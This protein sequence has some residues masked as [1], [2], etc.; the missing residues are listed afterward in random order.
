ME[1]SEKKS[2]HELFQKRICVLSGLGST[3]LGIGVGIGG[4]IFLGGVLGNVP[5]AVIGGIVGGFM[6]GAF[7][8]ASALFL[9]VGIIALTSRKVEV[10]ENNTYEI[11]NNEESSENKVSSPPDENSVTNGTKGDSSTISTTISSKND[12]RELLI[13]E[14]SKDLSGNDD[15]GSEVSAN[16][17][18]ERNND[19]IETSKESDTDESNEETD[20]LSENTENSYDNYE[21]FSALDENDDYQKEF[22]E[23]DNLNV[24]NDEVEGIELKPEEELESETISTKETPEDKE[25]RIQVDV[26]NKMQTLTKCLGKEIPKEHVQTLKDL[27]ADC[28]EWKSLQD[29][30]EKY[31]VNETFKKLITDYVYFSGLQSDDKKQEARKFLEDNLYI[32]E[33]FILTYKTAG[34]DPLAILA[35][36]GLIDQD[37]ETLVKIAYALVDESSDIRGNLQ[38]ITYFRHFCE[39]IKNGKENSYADN[40]KEFKDGIASNSKV[41]QDLGRKAVDGVKDYL[42][43]WFGN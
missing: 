40:I 35:A 30:P 15:K 38:N 11:K 12:E 43:S 25:K 42:A 34:G 19:T 22:P 27:F 6:G 26:D 7:G 18:K 36:F 41:Y 5:G 21:F 1:V 37:D 14:E 23:D 8:I 20:L 10:V 16:E 4:G 3:G 17:I 2:N 28:A 39:V 13:K 9:N 33:G 31:P 29:K 32:T 24:S